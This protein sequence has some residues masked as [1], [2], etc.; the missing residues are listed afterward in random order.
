[1][2]ARF[3]CILRSTGT[4]T[5]TFVPAESGNANVQSMKT[6]LLHAIDSNIPRNIAAQH[7]NRCEHLCKCTFVCVL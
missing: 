6:V 5:N 7:S 4:G 2:S 1:M 3:V